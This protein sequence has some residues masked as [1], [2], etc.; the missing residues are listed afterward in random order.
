MRIVVLNDQYRVQERQ[1]EQQD[2]LSF[3]KERQ[4]ESITILACVT[5]RPETIAQTQKAIAGEFK[6]MIRVKSLERKAL[7][8][9]HHLSREGVRSS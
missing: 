6:G 8:C 9:S 7:E 5:T 3:I 2:L 1:F 4:P